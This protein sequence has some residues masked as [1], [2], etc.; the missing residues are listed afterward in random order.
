MK[1]SSTFEF[2]E[3][4]VTFQL[5]TLPVITPTWEELARTREVRKIR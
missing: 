4:N 3:F 1:R 2:E 5:Y